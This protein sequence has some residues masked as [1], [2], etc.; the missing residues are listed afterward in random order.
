MGDL[1]ANRI[2]GELF[3]GEAAMI[4]IAG[5]I[6]DDSAG[7]FVETWGAGLTRG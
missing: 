7:R 6:S 4:G 2:D 5:V 1:C 3:S